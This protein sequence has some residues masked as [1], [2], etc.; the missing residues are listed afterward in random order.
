MPS[1]FETHPAS[2]DLAMDGDAAEVALAGDWQITG[3]VPTWEGVLAGRAPRRVRFTAGSIGRWDSALALFLASATAWC[4]AEKAECDLSAVPAGARAILEQMDAA[5][6]AP[7]GPEHADSF[8]TTVGLATRQGVYAARDTLAFVGDCLIDTL[9]T[10]RRPVRFRWHDSFDQM[11]QCGAMGLPIV[12]L[13]SF[14]VGLTL[15]YQAAVELRQFGADIYVADLVGLSV[16][17]EMGPLM[18]AVIVAGRTGAAFAATLGNMQANE[19]IDALRALGI[20]PVRFLVLPRLLALGLM[21]PFLALYSDA[22][23]AIGGMVVAKS[24]LQIPASAYW[25]EMRT[26]VITR[27]IAS[28]LGKSVVFGLLVGLAGCS[29]GLRA[30]RSAEGVGRAATSAVVRSILLI[31][32]ADAVFAVVYHVLGI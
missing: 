30:D 29:A 11:Q 28:G 16:V 1:G 18:A 31:I 27:D 8:L 2:A 14:L 21:M 5:R 9:K 24:I 4:A 22:V 23:G 6:K 10:A 25:S 19:E 12:S 7:R 32:I 20:S 15:A 17:R 26:I 3:E 13:I